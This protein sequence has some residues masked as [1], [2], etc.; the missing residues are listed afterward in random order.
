M[1]HLGLST[2]VPRVSV[3]QA[4]EANPFFLSLLESDGSSIEPMNATTR[5]TA[6][7]IGNPA[8]W[9]KA[10]RVIQQ[11]G[12]YCEQV[13]EAE[14]ALAK[15]EIGQEGIGCEPASAVTLAGLKKLVR[16]GKVQPG[17]SVVLVLT[18]HTLKDSEYTID[19]HREKLLREDEK[20]GLERELSAKRRAT[21]SLA[22]SSDAVLEVLEAAIHA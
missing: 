14:I 10:A 5:A 3:I 22:A 6:I 2:K 7:R 18:G 20:V 12:G 1:K 8:S 4:E 15:A 16:Q 11:T 19:F 17:E 21:I 13:S 9:R